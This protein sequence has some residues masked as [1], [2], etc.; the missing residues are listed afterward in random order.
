M[1][2]IDSGNL[3]GD[4]I[5]DLVDGYLPRK[6]TLIKLAKQSLAFALQGEIDVDNWDSDSL[7]QNLADSVRHSFCTRLKRP[8]VRTRQY[9]EGWLL[10]PQKGLASEFEL[11]DRKSK[12]ADRRLLLTLH[13]DCK[14][15]KQCL[16]ELLAQTKFDVIAE[17]QYKDY[18]AFNK[19]ARKLF[20]AA[21]TPFLAPCLVAQQEME[22]CGYHCVGFGR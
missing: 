9:C 20:E 21:A 6:N 22:K 8:T 15:A 13:Y 19:A 16:Q 10:N 18:A 14:V 4:I 2:W 7:Y 3:Y 1:S 12:T 11:N 5:L 17:D